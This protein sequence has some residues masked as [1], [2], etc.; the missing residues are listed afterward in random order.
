MPLDA[1]TVEKLKVVAARANGFTRIHMGHDY[2]DEEI[3]FMVAMEEYK[4]AFCRPY[5]S[6]CEILA[7]LELVLGYRPPEPPEGQ[8]QP[9]P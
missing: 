7:V 9:A 1:E 5:P 6:C 4:T 3:R 8:G 2:T